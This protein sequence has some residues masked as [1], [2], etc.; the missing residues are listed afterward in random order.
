MRTRNSY[1]SNNS[2]VTI[3]R[4]RNKRRTPNVVETELRT[5]VQVAP[6]ADNRTMEE[7]LQAPTEGKV[8]SCSRDRAEVRER[9]ERRERADIKQPIGDNLKS[10]VADRSRPQPKADRSQEQPKKLAKM[11]KNEERRKN[12]KVC[13]LEELMASVDEFGRPILTLGQVF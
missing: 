3:P 12:V 11:K 4:R 6:M 10:T 13:V 1:F 2:Y 9:A 5:I 7:L 8:K